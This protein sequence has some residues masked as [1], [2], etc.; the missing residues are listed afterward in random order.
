MDALIQYIKTLLETN[1][2]ASGGLFVMVA[3][4]IMT[5]IYRIFPPIIFFLK[6]RF[7]VVLDIPS[8]DESFQWFD[9]WIST[10]EYSKRTKLI[11]VSSKSRKDDDDYDE[12]DEI[13]DEPITKNKK[14]KLFFSPAPGNHFFWYKK[15]FIW[16]NR[17]R[18]KLQGTGGMVAL[19]EQYTLTMVGRNK[20]ILKDMV[21][22]AR[23]HNHRL[24]QD[25]VKVYVNSDWHWQKIQCQVPRKLNTVILKDGLQYKVVDDIKEF[26]KKE[27]WYNKM[28]IPYRRGYLLH[29][30]PGT[31][32]TSLVKALAGHLGI[33]IYILNIDHDM[34][35]NQFHTLISDVPQK[36]IIVI[37]DIDCLFTGKRKMDKKYKITFKTVLNAI[38]GIVSPYGTLLFL[39]TNHKL[40][41][42]PALIRPGRIDRQY[43]I[44]KMNKEQ[45]VEF[46]KLFYPKQIENATKFANKLES[47]KYTP[48]QLQEYFIDRPNMD[49]VLREI[50]KIK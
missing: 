46:F 47:N 21:K 48:A 16:I 20:E 34:K 1:I 17:N 31:G 4:G 27:K 33:P 14:A 25:K 15:R 13:P 42:D 45:I 3:G 38:D 7:I 37:E 9:K 39:T 24:E 29:G 32:K 2:I 10:L 35:E 30:C 8:S 19:Y 23:D 18:E 44:D 12:D 40:K 43:K 41:L 11:T 5:T 36:S 26:F 50:N 22:S 28:G 49:N 6:R